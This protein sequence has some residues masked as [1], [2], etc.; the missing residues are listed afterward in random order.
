[1]HSARF[2]NLLAKATKQTSKAIHSPNGEVAADAIDAWEK[3]LVQSR[4]EGL[5]DEE[6]LAV[7][8]IDRLQPI[9]SLFEDAIIDKWINETF[10]EG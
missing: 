7:A 4:H 8:N 10:K 1:M 5:K 3:V 2:L 6:K 9:A